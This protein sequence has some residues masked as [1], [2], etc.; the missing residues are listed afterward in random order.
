[1]ARKPDHDAPNAALMAAIS[2]STW[3]ATMPRPCLLALIKYS[4]ALDHGVIG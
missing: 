3:C 1:M 2:S 4:K